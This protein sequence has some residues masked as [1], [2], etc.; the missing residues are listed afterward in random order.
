MNLEYLK[1]VQPHE[2]EGITDADIANIINSDS[3]RYRSQTFTVERIGDLLYNAGKDGAG[4]THRVLKAMK[5]VAAG[6]EFV[7]NKL[8]KIEHPSGTVDL[9]N[10]LQRDMLLGFAAD[11]TNDLSMPDVEAVLALATVPEQVTAADISTVRTQWNATLY[12]NRIQE[13]I[14]QE[15]LKPDHTAQTISAAISAVEV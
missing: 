8:K 9:G 13:A 4:I 12:V 1:D 2:G 11:A 6:Q 3:S 5:S 15:R 7:A 14:E 10:K